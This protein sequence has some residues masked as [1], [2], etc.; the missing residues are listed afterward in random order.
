ME[1]DKSG[2]NRRKWTSSAIVPPAA[3]IICEQPLKGLAIHPII[4]SLKEVGGMIKRHSHLTSTKSNF[5]FCP[6]S[7]ISDYFSLINHNFAI[8]WSWLDLEYWSWK[9]FYSSERS[10][11]DENNLLQNFS[12]KLCKILFHKASLNFAKLCEKFSIILSSE[13]A[14]IFSTQEDCK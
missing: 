13:L 5:I 11:D 1:V 2:W 9:Y 10:E 7:Q 3:D 14:I 12:G 4:E 8:R 6:R